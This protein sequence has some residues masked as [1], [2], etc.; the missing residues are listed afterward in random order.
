MA[1]TQELPTRTHTQG[2][3][4]DDAVPGED[5]S[6]VTKLFMERLQAW[7]HACGYL[8]DFI[9]AT[10][11]AHQQQGKEYEHVLKVCPNIPTPFGTASSLWTNR[12]FRS[13]LGRGITSTSS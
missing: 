11:K 7:K 6:E 10:Q 1:T 3:E 4:D 9:E 8:E 13:L 2:T 12:P 5:T